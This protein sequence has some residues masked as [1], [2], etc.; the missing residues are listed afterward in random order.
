MNIRNMGYKVVLAISLACLAFI[1]PTCQAET[2]QI[3]HSFTGGS[4]GAGANGKLLLYNDYLYGTAVYG[5]AYGNGVIFKVKTDGTHFATVYNFPVFNGPTAPIYGGWPS[6]GMVSNGE[7]FYGT[8]EAGGAFGWGIVFAFNPKSN[9]LRPL[10]AFKGNRDGFFPSSEL[11]YQNG[12]IYG[13]T[14]TGPYTGASI[15]SLDP[16]TR[17]ITVLHYFNDVVAPIGGPI[18]SATGVVYGTTAA[19]GSPKCLGGCGTVFSVDLSDKKFAFIYKFTGN[20]KIGKGPA[21]TLAFDDNGVAYGSDGGLGSFIKSSSIFSY[22]PSNNKFSIDYS[23]SGKSDGT[24]PARG[25]VFDANTKT[26]VGISDSSF[27]GFSGV[28]IGL[29]FRFDPNTKTIMPIHN[30]AADGSEGAGLF[31]VPIVDAAGNIY[32]IAN[33]AGALGH[34]TIYKITP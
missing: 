14:N 16:S 13:M 26:F 11:V 34:G 1:A 10:Y 27:G 9:V 21:S 2:I 12:T 32:G 20:A 18:V 23:F 31:Y 25:M 22:E 24:G 7:T 3:L 19:G 6:A 30:F 33:T 17:K 5:G 28:P 8:T 4:D 15:Y 29:A